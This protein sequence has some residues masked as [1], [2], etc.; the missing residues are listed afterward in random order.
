MSDFTGYEPKVEDNTSRS[1]DKKADP[2]LVMLDAG[3]LAVGLQASV[4]H[5]QA[6]AVAQAVPTDFDQSLQDSLDRSMDALMDEFDQS[7]QPSHPSTAIVRAPAQGDLLPATSSSVA[8]N[9][10]GNLAQAASSSRDIAAQGDLV[11][12]RSRERIPV[13]MSRPA[14]LEVERRQAELEHK[15][16]ESELQSQQ[17]LQFAE[18][19]RLQ[20]RAKAEAALDYQ[21]KGFIHA[22]QQ[23]EDRARDICEVEVAQTRASIEADARNLLTSQNVEL[24]GARQAGQLLA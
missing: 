6:Q 8:L 22:A 11:R 20:H 1:K 5:A 14:A 12:S 9:A 13:P 15:L 7:N 24:G 2:V 3:N 10:Q 23:Y 21:K 19:T 18:S 16:F 4:D 17:Y